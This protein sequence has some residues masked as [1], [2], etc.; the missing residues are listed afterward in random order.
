MTIATRLL[1]AALLS[2]ASFSAASAA[3]LIAPVE[4]PVATSTSGFYL[5]S[6]N[7][8]NFLNNTNFASGGFGG[9]SVNTDYD[10]GFYSALRAGYNFGSMGFV[11]PRAEIELGYGSA[12]VDEHSVSGVGGVGSINSYGD[13]RTFQGY[14]NGYLDIPLATDG[15][16]S[17]ITPYVGAG[18][19][20]INLDLRKQGVGGVGTLIDDSATK[21]AY[22]FDA[23]VGVNLQNIF[24]NT[25]VF[26]GTVLDIGYR[27]TGADSFNFTAVD[28]TESKT[29]FSTNAITLGL[30]KQF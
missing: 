17:A 10:V 28:G 25:S 1:V 20:F 2:T 18:A 21:F 7:E 6:I 26:E 27:Y 3:D 11:A 12:S 13:A 19:G 29:N 23:G 14:L 8:I 15:A 5:G 4:Q 16:F 24:K 30:R 22:H 9:I